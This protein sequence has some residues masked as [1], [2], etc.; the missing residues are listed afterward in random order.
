MASYV[1]DPSDK[2][3]YTVDWASWLASGETISTATW[4][5]GTGLTKSTSPVESKTGT[6]ATVWLEGGTAGQRYD[7]ACKIVTNQ[8]RTVE[9]TFTLQVEDR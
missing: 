3:D 5:V 6:A 7:V 8:N 2:L 1:K 9:R 4:T